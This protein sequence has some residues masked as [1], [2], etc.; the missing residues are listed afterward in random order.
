MKKLII[1][2]ITICFLSGCIPCHAQTG[3]TIS[4]YE[5]QV[6]NGSD[7]SEQQVQWTDNVGN[8]WKYNNESMSKLGYTLAAINGTKK[9]FK[10]YKSCKKS[11]II[12]VDIEDTYISISLRWY[13]ANKRAQSF[14]LKCL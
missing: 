1:L 9:Q 12:I 6:I 5:N 11:I 10:T 8:D 2:I 4:Y 14:Y 3:K 13:P 7:I